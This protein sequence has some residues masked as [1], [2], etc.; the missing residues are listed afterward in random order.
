MAAYS[1]DLRTRVLIAICL[2]LRAH[3]I[4]TSALVV[5]TRARPSIQSVD[6]HAGGPALAVG[7]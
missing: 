1:L 5:W 3:E 6:L 2:E 7:I 4:R